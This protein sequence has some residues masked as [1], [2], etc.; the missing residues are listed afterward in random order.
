MKIQCDYFRVNHYGNEKILC[1]NDADIWVS[2][3]GTQ[4]MK[5][6]CKIWNLCKGHYD[7]LKNNSLIWNIKKMIIIDQDGK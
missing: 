3:E 7:K 4:S 6:V 5:G 1:Q 2:V